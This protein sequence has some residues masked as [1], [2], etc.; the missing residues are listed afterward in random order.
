MVQR[1]GAATFAT[2]P[3]E[4]TW[5]GISTPGQ[6]PMAFIK[7]TRLPVSW[8]RKRNAQNEKKRMSQQKDEAERQSCQVSP[9]GGLERLAS[10]E[11]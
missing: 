6:F 7:T 11:L 4:R 1:K 5:H 8:S 10:E 2:R 9:F 3:N